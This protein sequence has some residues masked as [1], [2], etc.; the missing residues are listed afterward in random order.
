MA[1]D[2]TWN[3]DYLVSEKRRLKPKSCVMVGKALLE[4]RG[5]L[6]WRS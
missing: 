6:R 4:S 3:Q 5:A 2:G 1:S